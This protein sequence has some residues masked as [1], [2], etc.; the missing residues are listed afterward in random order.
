MP[1]QKEMIAQS[2]QPQPVFGGRKGA[3]GKPG[4]IWCGSG[5]I[6]RGVGGMGG[7]FMQNVL[8]VKRARKK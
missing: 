7:T 5:G 2:C 6:R 3:A 4:L 1:F 8:N